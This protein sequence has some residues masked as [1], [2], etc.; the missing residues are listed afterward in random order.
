MAGLRVLRS[1]MLT[2]ALAFAPAPARVLHNTALSCGF[3]DALLG[4]AP[5][6][7]SS[8]RSVY[9]FSVKAADGSDVP[10]ST[11]ADKRALLFVNVAS[12]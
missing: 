10:L 1:T 3:L 11:Y 6:P 2:S 9:D 7:A 8:A 12:Q 5:A 4:K